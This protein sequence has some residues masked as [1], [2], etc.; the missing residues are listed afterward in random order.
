MSHPSIF[1]LARF[2]ET[3]SETE[4]FEQHLDACDTCARKLSHLAR[5]AVDARG[6]SG[7]LALPTR[8]VPV[9]LPV[10]V[11]LMAC[12]AVLV[13][14]PRRDAQ[15][16]LAPSVVFAPEGQHG[17]SLDVPCCQPALGSA[18]PRDAGPG[19]RSD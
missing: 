13:S 8:R 15:L 18:L 2:V 12:I 14:T 16:T 17:T 7:A 9:Q 11:A 19:S 1:E 6:L 10:L 5:R 3:G 4:V